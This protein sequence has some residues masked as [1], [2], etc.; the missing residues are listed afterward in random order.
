[1]DRR[2]PSFVTLLEGDHWALGLAALGTFPL[3]AVLGGLA[4]SGAEPVIWLRALVFAGGPSAA[5]WVGSVYRLRRLRWLFRDGTEVPGQ[6]VEVGGTDEGRAVVVGY[7]VA[8]RA[9]RKSQELTG[10]QVRFEVGQAVT[11]LVDPGDPTRAVI[12]QVFRGV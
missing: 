8:G 1:M 9:Y 7:E 3:L 2:H 6:V 11:V 10:G 12:V 5:C 4:L